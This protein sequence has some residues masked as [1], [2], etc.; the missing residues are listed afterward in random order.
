MKKEKNQGFFSLSIFPKS[1]RGD[2][3]TLILVIGVFLVCAVAIF[4]FTLFRGSSSQKFE[5]LDEMVFISSIAEQVRFYEN[6][7]L[8]PTDFLDIK[9]EN[10]VYIITLQKIDG[11]ERIFGVEYTIPVRFKSPQ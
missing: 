6:A 5:V 11:E 3:S 2:I 8:E 7:G 10:N 9:K 1:R 4:S